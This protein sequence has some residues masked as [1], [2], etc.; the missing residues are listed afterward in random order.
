[1]TDKINIPSFNKANVIVYG[2]LMLDRYW[3]GQ[4]SRI[5]PEAPVPVVCVNDAEARAGGAANVALNMAALGCQV[6]LMGLVGTDNEGIE[7]E[8]ILTRQGITCHFHRLANYPTV[9]KLRV[10]GQNQQLLRLD[11]EKHLEKYD[12]RE[13]LE[14]YQQQLANADAVVLSD[15]AKGTLFNVHALIQKAR[16]S[17]VPVFV[18]PKANDFTRYEGATLITP[19]LKEFE[20][21][22][23]PCRTEEE[24]TQ[25]AQALIQQFNFDGILVTRGKQG[26]ILVRKNQPAVNLCAHAREVYDVTGAGDTVISL[27]AASMAAGSDFVSAATI[28]N[29]AAGLVVRKLGAASVSVHE[30]RRE[31]QMVNDSHVG[32]LTEAELLLAIADARA[33]GETVVMTN[34]CFDILHAGHVEYL[35]AA[36]SLGDRLIVAVNDDRS[37]ARLKGEERPLIPLTARVEVLAALRAVDWVVPFSEDTPARLIASVLPDILVK[38]SDYQPHEIAGSD[39]VIKNGGRVLTVPLKA[40]FS[41]S[42]II[43]KIKEVFV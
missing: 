17:Q 24:L 9:T 1:M 23:G 38:G 14:K 10:L 19:N 25:K 43:K 39:V 7:L 41:T 5:S 35:A 33:H 28:A 11:F 22:A 31:L 37:V 34:G 16:E 8:K 6:T 42:K 4:T 27:M 36:K 12:D 18:D 3:Y 32:V 15:Y 21:I 13:L 40:G 30:L 26:M 20:I 29:L 2:D